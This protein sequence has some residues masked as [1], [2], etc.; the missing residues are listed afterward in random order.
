[1]LKLVEVLKLV[2]QDQRE[3]RPLPAEAY[4]HVDLIIEVN[5]TS[6]RCADRAVKDIVDQLKH[7]VFGSV[8]VAGQPCIGVHV[9]PSDVTP[10]L[11]NI[12]VSLG[13]AD[14]SEHLGH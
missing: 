6:V 3:L 9:K 7:K 14:P 4:G 2:D 1:M 13:N 11:R 8:S 12:A 10:T 5:A